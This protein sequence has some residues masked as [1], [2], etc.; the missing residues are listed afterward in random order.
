MS[1]DVETVRPD[2]IIGLG[3]VDFKV[4]DFDLRTVL[5]DH[6]LMRKLRETGADKVM[7][8][9]G[10]NEQAYLIRMQ[11]ALLDSGKAQDL[12]AGILIPPETS[13]AEWTPQGAAKIAKFIGG[14]NTQD[15]R[16]KVIQLSLEI[17]FGFFVQGLTWLKRSRA[18]FEE[19]SRVP[20]QSGNAQTSAH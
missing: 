2:R 8:M 19:A 20:S 7:P 1:D 5:I 12:L 15:D 13:A 3:G 11:S 10:E 9:D 17:V 4:V 14:L 18:S 16:E 6:Y